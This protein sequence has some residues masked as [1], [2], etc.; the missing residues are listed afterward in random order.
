MFPFFLPAGAKISSSAAAQIS[1]PQQMIERATQMMMAHPI[2]C[3]SYSLYKVHGE[4]PHYT[5]SKIKVSN[6]GFCCDAIEERFWVPQRTFQLTVLKRNLYHYKQ[7]GNVP[8]M[9]K[10]LHRTINAY[11]ESLFL[12]VKEKNALRKGFGGLGV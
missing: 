1:S 8:W 5:L 4:R 11:K 9:L 10:I 7:N 6:E 2:L 12:R 3:D